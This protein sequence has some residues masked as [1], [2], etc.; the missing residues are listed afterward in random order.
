ME[1]RSG[2]RGAHQG[3]TGATLR[4][5]PLD[6]TPFAARAG[7]RRVALFARAY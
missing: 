7:G 4:C 1:R 6:Q 2:T 3:G 5:V